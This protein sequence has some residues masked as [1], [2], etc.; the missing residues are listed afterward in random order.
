[1]PRFLLFVFL[2]LTGAAHAAAP[3]R[4]PHRG[5]KVEWARLAT[6]GAHWDR[7]AG[8]DERVLQLMRTESSLNIDGNW[9]SARVSRLPELCEFPFIFTDSIAPLSDEDSRN[10]AEYLRRGG[11]LLIDACRNRQINPNINRFLAA[12]IAQFKKQFPN[13]RVVTLEP[14][15]AVFSIYFK[16]REFPPWRRTDSFEPL[17]AVYVGDRMVAV[18]SLV[19]LQCGWAG[20][21]GAG[22]NA[23]E[24]VQMATNIYFYA[25]TR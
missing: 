14:S 11:F 4:E 6:A 13:S 21:G 25:M 18:I 5:G 12:Q 23:I 17:R 20:Y 22:N 15:H 1:M 9:R 3:V 8:S 10:L 7:H 2:G 24:C 16:M 19:G